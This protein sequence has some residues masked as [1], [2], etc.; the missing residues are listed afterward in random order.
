MSGSLQEFGFRESNYERPNR[1][2]ECGWAAQGEACHIGPDCTGHC[3]AHRECQPY[4]DG[5]R[6]RCSR[7]QNFGGRCQEGPL[8]DGTCP[9]RIVPCQPVRSLR[10]ARRIITFSTTAAALGTC[11]VLFGGS[12][13]ESYRSP[14]ALTL[15]HHSKVQT[16]ADCHA[17]A[18]GDFTTWVNSTFGADSSTGDTLRCLK[19][20]RDLGPHPLHAHG[21]S[22][23]EMRRLTARFRRAADSVEKPPLDSLIQAVIGTTGPDTTSLACAICHHEH[24]GRDFDLSRMTNAQCQS[25]HAVRFQSFRRGHPEFVGFPYK[26]RTRLQFDHATHYR[27][28]FATFRRVM[29]DAHPP[30][31]LSS[32]V[33]GTVPSPRSCA[34][35]H[36]S[37]ASGKT[38]PIRGFEQTCAA[39]HGPEIG[40]DALPGIEFFAIPKLNTDDLRKRG[41][42]IGQWPSPSPDAKTWNGASLPPLMDLLLSGDADLSRAREAIRTSGL[43]QLSLQQPK[44]VERYLW[45]IKIILN[46]LV[47]GGRPALRHRLKTL[48][49]ERI[50]PS[51][52]VTLDGSVE[53]GPA[54]LDVLT[55][56]QTRW[57]PNLA[58][59]IA[60]HDRG[61]P[62]PSV[63]AGVA[64]PR[65]DKAS[66]SVTV[67]WYSSDEDALSTIRYRVTG[68]GDR[69]VRT[70]LDVISRVPHIAA[71]SKHM[72]PGKRVDRFPMRHAL[73]DL[74]GML[75]DPAA[76]Y[77][78]LGCHTADRQPDGRLA[79]NWYGRHS[80]PGKRAFTNFSHT[81]HVKLLAQSDCATCHQ[82]QSEI[83]FVHPEFVRVRQNWTI[84][85]NPHEA[86]TAGFSSLGKQT[87]AE[88]H[89]R[90]LAGDE[91]L[92]CHNY[93]IVRSNEL[94][95]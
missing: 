24:R 56:D 64:A 58:D 52:L 86:R 72:T 82:I 95:W 75:A 25:C 84:N 7:P 2:W 46:D 36:R 48:L 8:P 61:V 87:C 11:L 47:R 27:V 66:S 55:A 49:A 28:H 74:F 63:P 33:R 37:D 81:P 12:W 85:T 79:I 1:T 83:N 69:L 50:T 90:R 68:H 59:E 18:E 22:R 76:S 77:R 9:Q 94:N 54:F 91:C 42:Q 92:K 32:T 4:K 23:P 10:S 88:C 26:R 93:H 89:V 60:Q 73:S 31:D 30:E 41:I 62:L 53:A 17:A 67:G 6:Y 21:L 34:V 57:F 70:W 5:D 19:C 13:G 65:P 39:C 45:G 14:G 29:P 43:K 71:Q 16:C 3:Q 44:V 15:Q 20:H 35:C 38:W 51:E 40:D 80:S 78:C